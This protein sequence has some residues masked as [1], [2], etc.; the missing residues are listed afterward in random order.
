MNSIEIYLLL[1]VAGISFVGLSWIVQARA[2]KDPREPRRVAATIPYIGHAIGLFWYR[3]AYYARVYQKHK[4]PIISISMFGG[5]IHIIGSAD[6][7]NSLHRRAKAVSFWYLE[8]RFTAELGT[9]SRDA[10][11]KLV[12]N[13]EPASKDR[14][15]LIEGLKA[16]QQAVSPVGGLDEMIRITADN[17]KNRLDSLAS[18]ENGSLPQRRAFMVQQTHMEIRRWKR[19][20]DDN[21]M[22]MLTKFLPR[23]LASK[24]FNGRAVVVQ[25]MARYFANGDYKNGSSLVKARH[26]VLAAEMSLEDLAK[27]ECVNGIAIM[28][29]TVPTAFWTIFH[30]F[31]DPKV[32]EEVRK[33]VMEITSKDEVLETGGLKRRINLGKLKYAPILSSVQ[34][35]A[36]RFRATGSGP[37]MVMEDTVVA[38]G[39]D[40]FLLRK[41]SVVIIANRALH[42]DNETCGETADVFRADRFCGKVPGHAFRGFGG[43]LNLCPGRGFALAEVAAL[44]AMLVMRFDVVPVGEDGWVE[45]GQ[46]LNNMSVQVAGPDIKVMVKIVPRKNARN[47]EWSF[48]L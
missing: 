31:S 39:D 18:E 12:A 38:S 26:S 33:Q 43:G 20:F 1:A 34:Q 24:A 29:N 44:V 10:S 2:S 21:L 32:L 47:V 5:T 14:S 9:L 11:K 37:R 13:L 7:M 25:A 22:L 6:L 30:I 45:P 36:L 42:F 48:E 16:T 3:S 19:D 41:D 4:A 23:F 8:A 17:T 27:F 35:E 46:N 28:T 40:K 15:L